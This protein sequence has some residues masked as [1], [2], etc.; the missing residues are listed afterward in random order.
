M[1][2]EE[3]LLDLFD[4]LEQQAEGIA[5]AER[6]ALVAEQ[7][8]AEY[9]AVALADRLHASVGARLVLD[10]GGLGRL[11]GQLVRAGDG[12]CLLDVEGV[13][14]VVVTAA[15]RAVRG[16]HDAGRAP[17]TRPLTARLGLGSAL[18]G[19]A[20][21]RGDVALHR[22]DGSACRGRLGRVGRDFVEVLAGA[23]SSDVAGR[24]QLEVLPFG[25]LAALRSR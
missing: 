10:V 24:A 25:T 22:R 6:D 13:D 1:R 23:D 19:L 16:L 9:A 11:D 14:W 2:W 21:D 7:S 20:E 5:L 8:R 12:W 18:R 4:D 17:G 15:V 3:R